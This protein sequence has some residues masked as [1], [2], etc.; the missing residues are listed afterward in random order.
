VISKVSNHVS[1][2][3][4]TCVA[5]ITLLVGV[6]LVCL[7]LVWAHLVTGRTAWT[8]EQALAFQSASSKL[9]SLSHDFTHAA[10][11]GNTETV[12]P[13][14]DKAQARFAE[15]NAQLESARDRPARIAT[16]LRFTGL[17]IAVTGGVLY[18]TGGRYTDA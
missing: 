12:R 9:H 14:L 3:W 8:E 11:H 17:L 4:R 13:E 7:S 6:I 10:E 1:F 16:I 15:L 5:F 18:L 2:D